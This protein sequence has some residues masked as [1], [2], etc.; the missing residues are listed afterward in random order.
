MP[1]LDD[2]TYRCD[3]CNGV[4]NLVRNENWSEEKAKAEFHQYFPNAKWE[5]REVVCDDCWLIVRP[6]K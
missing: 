4:F 1:V 3:F 6:L 2:K 5:M